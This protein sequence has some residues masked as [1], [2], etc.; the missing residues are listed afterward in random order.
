MTYYWVFLNKQG[1]GRALEPRADGAWLNELNET[2]KSAK[3]S[4][5]GFVDDQLAGVAKVVNN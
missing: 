1:L 2:S 3:Q 4:G 5:K